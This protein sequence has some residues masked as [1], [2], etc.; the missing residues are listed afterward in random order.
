M[1]KVRT[2]DLAVNTHEVF[3][4]LQ[5]H[6]PS[7]HLFASIATT[8]CMARFPCQECLEVVHIQGLCEAGLH[9]VES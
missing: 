6:K 8:F 4:K 1:G 5:N 3:Y 7:K 9:Y 2:K